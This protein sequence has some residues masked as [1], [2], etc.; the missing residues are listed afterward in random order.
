MGHHI[1]FGR[2]WSGFSA[3]GCSWAGD[4]GDAEYDPAAAELEA[5]VPRE[6]NTP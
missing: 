5:G 1:G 6:P 2:V 4:E 3:F